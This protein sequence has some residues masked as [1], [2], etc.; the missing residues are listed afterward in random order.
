MKDEIISR[1]E[2]LEKIEKITILHAVES[3][4]R[5]WGFESPDSD[6]DVRFIYIREKSFYLRIDKTRD[7]I[8][9]PTSYVIFGAFRNFSMRGTKASNF[10]TF[11]DKNEY[12]RNRKNPCL[13][14][15]IEESLLE[16]KATV[17]SLDEKNSKRY[18]ELNAL[19]LEAMELKFS[20]NY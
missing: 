16:L 9:L 5:A 12:A 3:G 10:R 2:A 15:Y 14:N 20:L 4:S 18:D 7:V 1:L 17:A 13:N 19:F 8:E 11:R 6:Y